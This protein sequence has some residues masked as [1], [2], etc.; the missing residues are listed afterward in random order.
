M[1]TVNGLPAI[2]LPLS[3]DLHRERAQSRRLEARAV[4]AVAVVSSD[5]V[6]PLGPHPHLVAA[7]RPGVA[8]GVTNPHEDRQLHE[9]R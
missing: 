7:G 4:G 6:H 5:L 1:I 8:V 2:G 3:S 9:H